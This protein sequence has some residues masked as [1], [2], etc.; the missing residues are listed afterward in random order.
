MHGTYKFARRGCAVIGPMEIPK[1]PARNEGSTFGREQDHSNVIL[2]Q[3][4]VDGGGKTGGHDRV[5]GVETLG[6][7]EPYLGNPFCP[8]I[9]YRLRSFGHS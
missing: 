9:Q 5:E 3:C 7:V 4:A 2:R 1:I 8:P 6:T